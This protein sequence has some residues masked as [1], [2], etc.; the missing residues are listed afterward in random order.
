VARPF[1]NTSI[2]L[3]GL[4]L[5]APLVLAAGT[6]G[7]VDEFADGVALLPCGTQPIG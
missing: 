1:G 2:E 4:S 7:Y 3:A 5:A 6:G